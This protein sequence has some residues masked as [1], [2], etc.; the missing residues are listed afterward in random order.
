[1]EISTAASQ[2]NS[3]KENAFSA[4]QKTTKSDAFS[5]L[6]QQAQVSFKGGKNQPF[7]MNILSQTE[8]RT[9]LKQDLRQNTDISQEYERDFKP[10]EKENVYEEASYKED[11]FD[12]HSDNTVDYKAPE[13]VK[14]ADDT[15]ENVPVKNESVDTVQNEN[16][17]NN[18][19][20]ETETNEVVTVDTNNKNSE[21]LQQAPVKKQITVEIAGQMSQV[22]QN[23][24]VGKEI[25]TTNNVLQTAQ[26]L[27]NTKELQNI[28]ST[29]LK[30]SDTNKI[31]GD[32]SKN[33]NISVKQNIVMSGK[34]T[35][36][37]STSILALNTG[38]EEAEGKF[39]KQMTVLQTNAM[40]TGKAQTSSNA[41]VTAVE[42]QASEL[43]KLLGEGDK[44]VVKSA[45]SN[46]PVTAQATSNLVPN[47]VFAE[48]KASFEHSAGEENT[49]KQSN[50]NQ[51]LLKNPQ[52]FHNTNAGNQNNAVQ[53]A[54]NL[55]EQ[56]LQ[57]QTKGETFASA[58]KTAGNANIAGNSTAQ[59][60]SGAETQAVG[61]AQVAE[62]ASKTAK[63]TA[64]HKPLPQNVKPQEIVKQIKVDIAKAALNGTKKISI[65]LTPHDLGRIN[66]KLEI[67]SEGHLRANI[68]AS[69]PE[70]LEL[71]Q[72]DARGLERALTDAG[73]KTDSGSLEFNFRGENSNRQLADAQDNSSKGHHASNENEM[74]D[75]TA[76]ETAEADIE[77]DDGHNVNIKV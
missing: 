76:E 2:N 8:T 51:P 17:T 26:P 52:Q 75:K 1:M 6:V 12:E 43:S 46:A 32:V 7:F 5:A 37:T 65:Q 19:I 25:K 30:P 18:V 60:I 67:S 70:T 68:T 29:V 35:E 56:N 3:K 14:K 27:T 54:A 61:G 9:E 22:V 36:A 28:I 44:V 41:P 38:L 73:L 55:M 15:Y 66:V 59:G 62:Q 69:R 16:N 11:S 50:K 63:A 33:T 20:N 64:A 4:S 47:A 53:T 49:G 71:L 40:Q 74:N 24:A 72:K 42:Q 23:L 10:V 21:N 34:Q 45:K 48:E 39:K 77:Y 58:L 31:K 13:H 57:A